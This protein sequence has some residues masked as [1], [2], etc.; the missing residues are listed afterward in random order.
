V[1]FIARPV[2]AP[3]PD[4]INPDGKDPLIRVYIIADE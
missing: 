4:N 3:V 1:V 2:I